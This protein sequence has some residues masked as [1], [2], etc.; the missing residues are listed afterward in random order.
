MTGADGMGTS[1]EYAWTAVALSGLALLLASI[2]LFRVVRTYQHYHDERAAVAL[3]KSIG[4]TVIAGGLLLSAVGLV[5]S[6][7]QLSVAGL[8]VSRG[9]FLVLLSTLVLADVRPSMHDHHKEG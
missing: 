6:M 2:Y 5:V 8:S 1:V 9:A 3:A 7:A 4:L